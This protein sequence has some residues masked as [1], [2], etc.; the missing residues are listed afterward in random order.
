MVKFGG[1]LVKFILVFMISII[2]FHIELLN[3][4]FDFYGFSLFQLF[5]I[6]WSDP[7]IND[8]CS[9]N[10]LRGAG[11][12]FGPD[13][14]NKFLQRYNLTNIVRSHECKSDGYEMIHGGNVS[15]HFIF[16]LKLLFL[17]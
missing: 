5:D 6:L 13:V 17:Q 7:C 11:T 4:K 12:V 8:G 1:K 3:Y 9:P 14:T 2:Y 16:H 10:K 15:S